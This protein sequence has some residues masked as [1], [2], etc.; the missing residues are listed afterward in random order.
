M[1]KRIDGKMSII[2]KSAVATYG[3]KTYY[4]DNENDLCTTQKCRKGQRCYRDDAAI[5]S[6]YNTEIIKKRRYKNKP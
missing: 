3:C 6:M 4:I 1:I 2:Y 5:Q